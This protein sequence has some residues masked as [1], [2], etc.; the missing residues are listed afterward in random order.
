MKKARQFRKDFK[1]D[2]QK[3]LV[4][5]MQM[6][7]KSGQQER[8]TGFGVLLCCVTLQISYKIH[9]EPESMCLSCPPLVQ[10]MC[11]TLVS[12]ALREKVVVAQLQ[13]ASARQGM[14]SASRCEFR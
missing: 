3:I 9:V 12:G 1:D 7:Q 2:M 4:W 10:G 14:L 6:W 5:G 8:M 13:M 11:R